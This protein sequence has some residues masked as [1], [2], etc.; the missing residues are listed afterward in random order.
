MLPVTDGRI[1]AVGPAAE[2]AIPEGYRV[3]EAAVVT[4]G[5][6]DAH[7]HIGIY[8]NLAED[9]P[10]ESKCAAMGGVTTSLTYFRTGQYYLNKG[11]PYLEFF[12]DVL[13]QAGGRY[14]V[15]YG[16]H[17]M[18]A[19]NEHIEEMPDIY[20]K[21]GIPE[22][23][24]KILA[25]VGARGARAEIRAFLDTLGLQEADRDDW[26]NW[27]IAD[28]NILR[29]LRHGRKLKRGALAGNRFRITITDIAVPADEAQ[30]R[31]EAIA[32]ALLSSVM[33]RPFNPTA[34]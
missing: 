18:P 5:L 23:E 29:A 24:R 16:F 1:V 14:H 8:R 6:I 3:L 25:G 28:V 12:K 4:P 22:A 9:A 31:A 32:A 19:G 27:E 21:L 13:E 26:Q 7:M 2:V 15:D 10:T 30:A 20:D 11:G 17:L 33:D 34:I